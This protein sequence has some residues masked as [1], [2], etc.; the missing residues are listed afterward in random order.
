[1]KYEEALNQYVVKRDSADGFV[2]GFLRKISDDTKDQCIFLKGSG[3]GKFYCGIYEARPHDCR[4]F[5]PISCD[6]V[7]ADLRYDTKF[8]PGSPFGP[9]RRPT[10][11]TKRRRK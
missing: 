6:D 8:A 11:P 5:T 10:L 3:S 2:V 7:D 1:M 4:A 9:K